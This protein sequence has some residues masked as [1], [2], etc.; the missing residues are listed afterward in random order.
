MRLSE[1]KWQ[2]HQVRASLGQEINDLTSPQIRQLCSKCKKSAIPFQ[3]PQFRWGDTEP[4]EWQ[5]LSIMNIIRFRRNKFS[6]K[7]EGETGGRVTCIIFLSPLWIFPMQQERG[8]V[9]HYSFPF[10]LMWSY[11]NYGLWSW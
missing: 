2:N 3:Q 4:V 10:S 8:K 6:L 5:T 1:I 7:K 11:Y 9:P